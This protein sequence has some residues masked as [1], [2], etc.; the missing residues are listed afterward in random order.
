WLA[1]V[2]LA[3]AWIYTLRELARA[4]RGAEERLRE[5]EARLSEVQRVAGLG[6]W[7]WVAATDAIT[8]SDEMCRIYGLEPG[9]ASSYERFDA[10][11]HPEDRQRVKDAGRC[12]LENGSDY[13]MEH[14]I[15]RPD[16]SIRTIL[17]RARTITDSSG[18]VIRLVG[19]V[20]DVTVRV[21]ESHG[22]TIRYE[23]CVGQGT[24]FFVFLPAVE[25][26]AAASA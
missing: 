26:G 15:I 3:G 22:G 11:V 20:L 4:A 21:V 23:T 13:A 1:Q 16:G 7:E 12:A 18:A 24:T 6:I 17:A 25:V 5:S 10:L 19:T 14:R 8:V 9:T 2:T